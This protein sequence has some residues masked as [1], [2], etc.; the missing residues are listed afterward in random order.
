MAFERDWFWLGWLREG[1]NLL[2]IG[3][4]TAEMAVISLGGIV[5]SDSVRVGGNKLDAAIAEQRRRPLQY[6]NQLP[7]ALKR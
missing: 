2:D 4:G 5:A 7:G 6:Q 1:M 3:G